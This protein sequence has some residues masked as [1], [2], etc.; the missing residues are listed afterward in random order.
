MG[1]AVAKKSNRERV[2]VFGRFLSGMVMPNIGAFI[3]WG[4]ITALFIPTGWLPNESLSSL[5]SPMI[6]YL[7]PLL[8]GYTGG[9]ILGGTRGG[10]VGSVA[11][12]GVVV[13]VDIPMFIGAMIMGPLGGYVIKKFDAGVEGKIPTGFEMLVNNFSS[14]IIGMGLALLAFKGIGP[15]VLS[16]T[17]GL[18]NAVEAMVTANLLPL[19]SIFIEPAKILFL[20]NAINHGVLSPLGIAQ[21]QEVGKSVFF[22]L[23]ANPGPGLG[24]LCAYYVFGKGMAKNSAPGAIIIHFLGG[25]HEIYFPYVLMNPILILAV[26]AGGASGVLTFTILGAGLVAAASPG[27]IFAVMAMTPKGGLL[28]VLAG[29]VVAAVVSFLVAGFFI[30]RAKSNDEELEDAKSKMVDL[31]GKESSVIKVSKNINKVVFACDAGMGSSAMGASKLR[32]KFKKAGIDVTVINSA[33]NEI[34]DDADLVISHEKLT[35]RARTNAPA[36]EHVSIKDFL[37]TPAY[38]EIVRNFKGSKADSSPNENI[39]IQ[40]NIDNTKIVET[41]QTI[42]RKENIKLNMDTVDKTE[43]IKM[44]G[45]LLV[46][47]GYVE[48]DYIEAMIQREEVVTTYIGNNLAIPHGIGEAKKHIKKSGI[49]VLQ[50]PKG[51]SFG[52][53]NIAN[54]VIGIAGKG[55]EHLM[56]LSNIASALENEEDVQKLIET[57]DVNLIYKTFVEM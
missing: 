46:N 1:E 43:A 41:E 32:S 19:A 12:M 30:K 18:G 33:I 15:V 39:E 9:K 37:N 10:V 31:K 24:I 38:D 21:A 5:V 29:V 35:S 14:G 4:L 26:I 28:P 53:G 17:N 23:E 49:V 20:N 55:D 16:L 54:L 36:A 8:I 40:E 13:G 11:T 50:Y 25:I 56:I 2:Q 3:A 6:L 57:E 22:L 44:A 45:R 47:G 48:E 52:N 7:L 42:L 34:P 51:V 27:S